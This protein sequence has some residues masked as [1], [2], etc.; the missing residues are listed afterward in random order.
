M[1]DEWDRR[2]AEYLSV[3]P[4]I[5]EK[6]RMYSG[7]DEIDHSNSADYFRDGH[8][9]WQPPAFVLE[10]LAPSFLAPLD[11]LSV[12]WIYTIDP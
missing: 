4:D 9:V 10:E 8:F 7:S 2:Y 6:K 3:P 12:E 11:D 5:E 1:V